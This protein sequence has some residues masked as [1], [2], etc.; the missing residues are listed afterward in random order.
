MPTDIR[1]FGTTTTG[2]TVEAVTLRAGEL[3]ARLITFG[4]RLQDLRLAGTPW[5]LIL[6]SDSL[7][8]YESGALPWGGA[9]VGPVAN[10]LGGAAV[11]IA[12]APW[13]ALPNEGAHLLHSGA[14]GISEQNWQIEA[15]SDTEVTFRLDLAHGAAALPGNRVLRA[16][17]ALVPPATLALTLSAETDAETLM[18]LAHHP[19]WTLDG[20]ADIAGHR[21]SVAATRMLPTDAQNL[22]L[23]PVDVTGTGYDLRAPRP[24]ADLPPLDHNYC[25]GGTGL[26]PVAQLTGASGVTLALESDAPGLQVY[27]GRHLNT[28]PALGLTG[29]PYGPHAGL[30]LEPQMW[31]DAPHH[32]DFPPI[33]LRPGQIWQQD[34]R[35]HLHRTA[36]FSEP[37]RT[38]S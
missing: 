30:A 35:M 26:R 37:A 4:A 3:T 36:P 9:V 15:A 2:Q 13:K 19:Y 7:A 34:S 17:Y 23:P 14:A 27:D 16:R 21:L 12:G 24:L 5:P 6:G 32:P 20:R 29:A 8:A 28:A 22:P 33:T 18:N 38:V 25:P 1:R 11:T 31:P 10:R